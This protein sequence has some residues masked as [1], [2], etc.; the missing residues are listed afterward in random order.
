MQIQKR[1]GYNT[2]LLRPGE[3]HNVI[4]AQT[5]RITDNSDFDHTCDVVSKLS[6]TKAVT[7]VAVNINNNNFDT[8][9]TH[10]REIFWSYDY[11]IGLAHKMR[12]LDWTKIFQYKTTDPITRQAADPALLFGAYKTITGEVPEEAIKDV[13]F[14]PYP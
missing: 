14:D 3:P 13:Y 12:N 5:K 7:P 8:L 11:N 9:V 2:S 10:G 1:I 4:N 6:E